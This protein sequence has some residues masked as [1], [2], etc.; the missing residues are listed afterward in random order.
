[1]KLK[2]FLILALVVFCHS[3]FAMNFVTVADTE[4]YE[5]AVNLIATLHQHNFPMLHHIAVFD[6][7]LQQHQRDFLNSLAKVSVYDVEKKN[8]SMLQP[9]I[10]RNTGR[11]AGRTA[12]GWYSW[13][14]VV[15]KQACDMFEDYIFIDAGISVTRPMDLLYAYLKQEGYFFVTC[16]HTIDQMVTTKVRDVFKLYGENNYVLD[17][18]GLAA[19]YQGI[20]RKVYDQYIIPVYRLADTITL[21]EDDGTAPKGF[22]WSRHDQTLF[23]II[24]R[25]NKFYIFSQA[26]IVSIGEMKKYTLSPG[27]F[28]VHSRDNINAKSKQYL[29]LKPFVTTGQSLAKTKG[30]IQSQKISSL[31]LKRGYR[32]KNNRSEKITTLL[33]LLAES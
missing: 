10:V 12:R 24:A 19:G 4:Y 16:G 30:R 17:C 25:L 6:I 31:Y 32:H 13:K 7:G 3:V 21:F 28:I 14:P 33:G 9:F 22:G 23:S 1:M 8:P 2:T 15:L 27:D 20:T 26:S 18:F 29:R 11:E 5:Q